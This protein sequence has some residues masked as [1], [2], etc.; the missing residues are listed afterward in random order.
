MTLNFTHFSPLDGTGCLPNV[1]IVEVA[2]WRQRALNETICFD[3]V[4]SHAQQRFFVSYTSDITIQYSWQEDQSSEFYLI[5]KF[6]VDG[7]Y[8]TQSYLRNLF[9]A[10]WIFDVIALLAILLAFCLLSLF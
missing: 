6:F 7:E 10:I 4:Q 3:T 1:T 2:D 5:V 9:L 8:T